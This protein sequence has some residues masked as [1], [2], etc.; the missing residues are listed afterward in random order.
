M[1]PWLPAYARQIVGHSP[2][3]HSHRSATPYPHPPRRLPPGR[4]QRLWRRVDW[5]AP[6]RTTSELR[7]C[8]GKTG[9]IAMRS[10]ILGSLGALL[11][12]A[13]PALAE[14]ITFN[15]ASGRSCSA[16]IPDTPN[17]TGR[18]SHLSC[19]WSSSHV[20]RIELAATSNETPGIVAKHHV[21]LSADER[22]ARVVS[23]LLERGYEYTDMTPFYYSKDLRVTLFATQSGAISGT[24]YTSR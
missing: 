19:E 23:R 8:G 3:E 16:T 5:Q 4:A 22:G 10:M 15:C 9:R 2:D 11:L 6:C 13:A 17:S 24:C 21:V 18:I 1:L 14:V 12:S 7:D 20:N